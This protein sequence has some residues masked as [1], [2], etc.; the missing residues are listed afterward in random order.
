MRSPRSTDS[1]IVLYAVATLYISFRFVLVV[2]MQFVVD[3]VEIDSVSTAN[4]NGAV[5]FFTL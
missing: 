1:K 5:L 2:V 3:D 4:S